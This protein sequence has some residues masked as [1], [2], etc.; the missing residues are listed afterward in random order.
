MELRTVFLT[1]LSIYS[2]IIPLQRTAGFPFK[3]F[4]LGIADMDVFPNSFPATA[5]LVWGRSSWTSDFDIV[6]GRD[7]A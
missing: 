4:L 6:L 5:S 3:D 2:I 7:Q 1:V